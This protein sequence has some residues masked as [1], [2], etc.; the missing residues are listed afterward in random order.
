MEDMLQQRRDWINEYK[1][2]H[3]NKV[4][5]DI[6][7]FYDKFNTEAP[8]SPEEEAAKKAAEE[9]EAAAKKGKKGAKKAGKKKKGKKGKKDD[10]EEKLQVVKI[11][12][13]EVVTKFD[14][15]YDEF[16]DQWVH[17]DES[18]NQE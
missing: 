13:T 6:K 2:M 8:L 11:G 14:D 9:E 10:G 4:P 5:E 15:F 18:N 16:N 7:P 3:Q 17:R 12:P 1:S